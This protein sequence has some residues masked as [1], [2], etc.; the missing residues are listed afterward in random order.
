MPSPADVDRTA[1]QLAERL[2][3]L[4]DRGGFTST[5]KYAVLIALMDLCMELTSAREGLPPESITTDQLARKVIELYWPHTA[6]F[7]EKGV[8]RQNSGKR[9]TPEGKVDTQIEIIQHIERFREKI[10]PTATSL[11]LSRAIHLAGRG[12]YE[13]LV[14]AVEWTLIEWPL[15]RLQIIGREEDRFLYDYAFSKETSKRE[16]VSYQRGQVVFDPTT[17]RGFNNALNLRPGVGASLIALSGLLRPLVYRSWTLMVAHLN[18][19]P[20]SPLEG[21]LFGEERIPLDPVRPGLMDVQR[22]RCFYC[23][24]GLSDAGKVHVDHFVPWSRHADNGIDNLVVAHE[25]CNLSKSDFLAAAEHVEHWRERS[26]SRAA[27]LAQIARDQTWESHPDRT[28]SVA[29]AIYHGLPGDAR[30]W[31]SGQKFELIEVPRIATALAA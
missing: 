29:R 27:D 12:A 10:G 30:L 15:P 2:I 28:V 4:L 11:S 8:L 18:N 17:N 24:K 23:E 19:L 5:Y 1:L 14:R 9:M 7:G 31:L 16:V 25:R 26:R 21:F 22:G 6:P 3:Q 20:E 13:E